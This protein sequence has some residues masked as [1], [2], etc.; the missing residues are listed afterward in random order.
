V[1]LD[2]ARGARTPRLRADQRRTSSAAS[3][4]GSPSTTRY[5][6]RFASAIAR[7]PRGQA[8]T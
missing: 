4:I 1:V 3:Q 2:N 5:A 6:A 7:S 8:V